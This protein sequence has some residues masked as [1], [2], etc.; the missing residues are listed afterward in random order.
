MSR[1]VV[2]QAIESI[3]LAGT[4]GGTFYLDDMRWV[5]ATPHTNTAVV[6]T[7]IQ[8]SPE[9]FALQQ[10]YPNPFNSSTTIAFTVPATTVGEHVQLTLFNLSGQ[11]LVDL[12]DGWRVAGEYN[13]Q[14]DGKTTSGIE[15][16]TGVYFYRLRIGDRVAIRKLMLM[17]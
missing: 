5:T 8:G 7:R 2:E 6:E 17:R 10:N 14:W 9:A 12:V 15:V 11:Q 13:L 3:L 4:L 1:F 16:A